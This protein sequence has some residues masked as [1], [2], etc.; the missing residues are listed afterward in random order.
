MQPKIRVSKVRHKLLHRRGVSTSSRP[1]TRE[2]LAL[3]L[4]VQARQGEPA[5]QG[6]V[7]GFTSAMSEILPTLDA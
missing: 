7:V 6:S 2:G 1:G 5:G 4:V 3:V